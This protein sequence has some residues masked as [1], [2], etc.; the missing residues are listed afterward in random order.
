MKCISIWQPFASLIVSGCKV[1]ETRTWPAPNSV[2]GQRI[3]IAATKCMNR[4]QKSYI[5]DEEFQA[6]YAAT[7]QPDILDLPRGALLGTAILERV[8]VMTKEMM[9]DVSKE[10]M[11]YGWWEDG[12]YAW[13]MVDPIQFDEPIPVTGRQGIYDYKGE[14]PA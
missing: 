8:S 14:L 2:V 5:D 10:E 12:C 11:M 1:N 7:G 13:H 6:V 9:E 4:T 3:G